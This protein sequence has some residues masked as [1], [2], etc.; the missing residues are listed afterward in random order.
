MSYE[1]CVYGYIK[2]DRRFDNSQ[3]HNEKCLSVLPQFCEDVLLWQGM[4]HLVG[5]HDSNSCL[6]N[7]AASYDGVEYEWN[8]WVQQ[9]QQM[10]GRMHW[11]NATVHLETAMSG[12][13]V[14]NWDY[15]DV[16][17]ADGSLNGSVR[18]EWTRESLIA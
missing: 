18:C 7:F 15:E 8:H 10:L 4:F 17:A 13:H 2:F 3:N 9:F 12:S 5:R 11:D 6:I 14:F 1:S 16:V